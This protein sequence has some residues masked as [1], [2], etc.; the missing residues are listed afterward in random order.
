MKRAILG[1][2]L[3]LYAVPLSAQIGSDGGIRGYVRDV[4]DASVPDA[5]I[6]VVDAAGTT[7][8]MASTD[9]RGVFW[10]N[11]LRPGSYVLTVERPGF[12][13]LTRR[14]LSVAPGSE[15][16]VD[17][18]LSPAGPTE[19]V[20]VIA[21]PPA[22]EAA[23]GGLGLNVDGSIL[24]QLP[25]SGKRGWADALEMTPGVISILH[26][27][28]QGN[29][30]HARGSESSGHLLQVDG[31]DVGS[32][33]FSA[34]QFIGLSTDAIAGTQVRTAILDAATP[35]TTGV[36]VNVVTQSGTNRPAGSVALLFM[37][38]R[39][40]ARNDPYGTSATHEIVQPDLAGGGPL[41]KGR[42]WW[43][44]GY[45]YIRRDSGVSRSAKNLR[46]L[47]A[48]APQFQPFDNRVR[49]HFTSLK[50][51]FQ[52]AAA[53]RLEASYHRDLNA[54]RSG[55]SVDAEQFYSSSLGGDA[56]GIA[57][58]S[59]WS[60]SLVTQVS[61]SY[62]DKSLT[63]HPSIL[64]P[65]RSEPSR[66]V[67]ESVFAS[68]GRL[69]GTGIIAR[70]D[71]YYQRQLFPSSKVTL[72][73]DTG[74]YRSG[75]FGFNALKTGL[76]L[77]PR[78][79]AD[80]RIMYANG[81]YALEE[82]VL[83]D[84]RNPGAGYM[85]FH[86]TVFS[87]AS[88]TSGSSTAH[89]YAIYAQNA[90]TPALRLTLSAGVRVDWLKNTDRLSRAVTQDSLNVG[91][92]LNVAYNI[93]A[94]GA[95]VARAS[96]GRL[97]D[98]P[99]SRA[100]GA[101][102]R[103]PMVTDSYDVDLDGVFE[104]NFVTPS[105]TTGFNREYDPEVHLGFVDEWTLRLARRFPASVNIDAALIRRSYRDR[106]A[107]VEVNAVFNG[108]VFAGYRNES[109]NQFYRWTNNTANWSV[110]SALELTASQS[111]RTFHMFA[112]YTRAFQHVA[113]TWMSR[114]PA[115]LIQPETFPN[116]RGIG[117]TVVINSLATF[118][119]THA[120]WQE[121][122]F[123]GGFSWLGPKGVTFGTLY[124]FNSGPYSGPILTRIVAPDPRFGPPTMTLSNGR[125]VSNPLA[126][127]LRFAF[128]TRGE[129]QIKA[130][131]L[132]VWNIRLGREFRFGRARLEPALEIFNVTNSAKYQ[133]FL[134]GGN[135]RFSP[136]YAIGPDGSFRG[137]NR[138]PP[139]TA[140]ASIRW[141]F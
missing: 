10:L 43:F 84:V 80:E 89:D 45:R 23:P 96:W 132:H 82:V 138:Q 104:T 98:M 115:A 19:T 4:H 76:Y 85:P 99:Q 133:A 42:A 6:T 7:S 71:N 135:Q 25:L 94:D 103:L 136:D 127:T 21:R 140:Q 54:R 2:A 118:V 39:W 61:A 73:A 110:Y 31:I 108:S 49:D 77:Q 69:F 15:V 8:R 122:V 93:T 12:T 52:A 55:G 50:L 63:G 106:P 56:V 86:R 47:R 48:L 26:D 38:V 111:L 88:V 16:V 123:R 131:A 120:G 37:P 60:S 130:P 34:P 90:W 109:F 128:P 114:D 107:L 117:S 79:R 36:V 1:V 5:V 30:Y 68:S 20:E 75:R 95:T 91:P 137:Q 67:H 119:S 126:T 66:A 112:G 28:S 64:G 87:D 113:G 33:F 22:I 101:P 29:L 116:N 3:L 72:R 44:A 18:R 46:D 58:T 13:T 9:T 53:H 78:L 134:P 41:V 83:L 125:V 139:R 70:L 105:S 121:H 65:E 59:S 97:H 57:L 141:S 129:G 74:Y 92:R 40:N 11:A 51:T 32:F 27:P 17:A 81:G 14:G 124:A 100:M 62:N 35:L 24:Q 102:F